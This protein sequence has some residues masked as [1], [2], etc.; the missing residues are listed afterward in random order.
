[1]NT[2]HFNFTSDLPIFWYSKYNQNHGCS[3]IACKTYPL[4]FIH[5]FSS[6]FFIFNHVFVGAL[7]LLSLILA[8]HCSNHVVS[9]LCLQ[10]SLVYVYD[11]L[12][13]PCCTTTDYTNKV[14]K[15]KVTAMD[16]KFVLEMRFLSQGH[17]S[18]CCPPLESP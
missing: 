9:V 11:L 16:W 5:M 2:K 15:H 1:M 12:L 13:I 17:R 18:D 7:V 8:S 4:V 3:T 14:M 10:L 6:V